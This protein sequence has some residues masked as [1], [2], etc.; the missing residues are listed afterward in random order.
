MKIISLTALLLTA[1]L[2]FTFAGGLRSLTDKTH[3]WAFIQSVGGMKVSQDGR[4]LIVDCNVSGLH[5]VT[6]EP[7]MVNSALGVREV[8][9][10]RVGQT[11]QLRLVTT[12][13]GKG[14]T[15]TC[16]P[17]DL[18]DYPAGDYAVQ[19]VDRDGT[20]HALGSVSLAD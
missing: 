1:A 7:T 20:T 5:E 16:K 4:S 6:V 12:V 8:K 2:T 14:I 18:S 19:Y 15:T 10:K 9:H 11:I 17:L 3:D 13:L